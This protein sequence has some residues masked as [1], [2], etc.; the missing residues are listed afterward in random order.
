VVALKS[1]RTFSTMRTA[2]TR[3]PRATTRRVA[4]ALLAAAAW[5]GVGGAAQAQFSMVPAPMCRP[6]APANSDNEQD[7][8]AE[9][10]RH[11]YACFPMRIY[12][13]L[14][15]PL[16]FGVI[17]LVTE[18]DEKGQITALQVVRKPAAEPVEPWLL[19]LVRRAAP[20][21]LPL[22]LPGGRARITE[23]FFVDTS[24]LFQTHSLTEG[25]QEG[26]PGDPEQEKADLEADA[27]APPERKP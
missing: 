18:I 12:H 10:A 26:P 11:L 25:Q 22:K 15:P 23:T 14:L 17:T 16:L 1:A 6:A 7:Y 20:F 27:A 13:G 9:V 5:L 3:T 24:G 21:P 19:A 8:R 2:A 4:T